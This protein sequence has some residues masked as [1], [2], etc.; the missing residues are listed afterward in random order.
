MNKY[1]Y[2]MII[3][4]DGSAYSGWQI[5]KNTISIQSTIQ[6]SLKII[7]REP[8]SIV[9]AGRTDAK[10]H[11]LGQTAHFVTKQIIDVNK[12]LYSLNCIL[13][14][15][16]RIIK[17]DS[18]DLAFHA[19]YSAK[20]KIYRYY[21]CKNKIQ[22]P[23]SR[24]YSYKPNV[25]I[26]LSLLKNA[27]CYF[28]GTHDFSSFANKQYEGSAKSKPIKTIY[29]IDVLE[30]ENNI[31]LEFEGDGF[32]YKMVRNIVGTLIDIASK[33]KPIDIIEKIFNS[34]DRKN[35]SSPVPGHGL[36]LMN[37]FY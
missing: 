35:A 9:A 29:R 20:S 33:K 17:I 31:I 22:D 14:K 34:K 4:Y 27:T 18:V 21:I 6:D 24:L 36:F 3:S 16:I 28:L 7:L 10:V 26:D 1:K 32:L 19:R 11:A 30:D 5:Q 12:T 15:D 8:I 23:F 25:D 2:K 13:P 37:I